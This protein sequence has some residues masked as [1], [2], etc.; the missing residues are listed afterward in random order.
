MKKMLIL[1]LCIPIES[2]VFL[3][4]EFLFF[5]RKHKIEKKMNKATIYESIRSHSGNDPLQVF[6]IVPLNV[7]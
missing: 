6:L 3:L 4:T 5:L 7:R 1:S 2:N